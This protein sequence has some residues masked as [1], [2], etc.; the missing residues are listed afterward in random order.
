MNKNRESISELDTL[1]KLMILYML[2]R[3][4]Q[5]VTRAQVYDFMLSR[6]YTSYLNVNGL[7]NEMITTGFMTSQVKGKRSHLM[8]TDQGREILVMFP[9]R[10]SA[11]IR[12]EITDYLI[13]KEY[14]LRNTTSIQSN[15]YKSVMGDYIAELSAREKNS[16]LMTIRVSVPSEESARNVCLNWEKNNQEIY[17]TLMQKLL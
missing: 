10:I 1:Y 7:I 4:D 2:D 13:E 5:P 17:K 9:D 3:A 14:D 8:L 11:D 16:E 6:D 12:K 15:Y